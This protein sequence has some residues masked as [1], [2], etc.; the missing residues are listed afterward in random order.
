MYPIKIS[1]NKIKFS[2]DIRETRKIQY[3]QKYYHF[4]FTRLT[5]SYSNPRAILLS[6]NKIK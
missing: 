2:T 3:I 5:N 1:E 6:E 4:I